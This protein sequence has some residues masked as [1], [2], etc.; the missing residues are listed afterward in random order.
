MARAG[1]QAAALAAANR[2]YTVTAYSIAASP[3]SRRPASATGTVDPA[4]AQLRLEHVPVNHDRRRHSIALRHA[5]PKA[6]HSAARPG[7]GRSSWD[8]Y[9]MPASLVTPAD[10]L[11]PKLSD[12][13]PRP[14]ADLK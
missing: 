3:S 10:G 11:V 9:Q 4:G 12:A 14:D 2:G 1:S 6:S 7:R 5:R 8:H 13:K